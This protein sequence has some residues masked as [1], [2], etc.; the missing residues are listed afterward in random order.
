M[1]QIKLV[2]KTLLLMVGFGLLIVT[3][4]AR[5]SKQDENE[6]YAERVKTA[7]IKGWTAYMGY[8]KGQDAVNPIAKKGHNWYSHSL[9]MTP[10]DAFSTMHVMG[11]KK[12]MGEAKQLIFSQLNFDIDMEIQQ[13]EIAI[14]IMGGL[15]SAYQLDGDPRFLQLA[16]DLGKRMLPVFESKTGMPYRLVNLKTGAVSGEITNPCEIGS[17][18]LEYGM[19]SKLTGN[20][21]YYEKCKR[22]VVATFDRRSKIGLVGTEININT[23]EWVNKSAHLS[24]RIDAYYEY[25]LKGWLLFGDKDLKRMWDIHKKAIAKYLAD[26]VSSGFWYGYADMDTGVRTATRFGALDCF[27]GAVLCL[28]RNFKS[29][30]KLQQSIYKMWTLKGLEPETIDYS[31]MNIIDKYYMIR[32]EAIESTYYLWHYTKDPQ[33]F[34]QGKQMFESIEKY[35][36]VDNGYV[37]IR[38]VETMEKWD[39]LESFF[40]A[41]TMKY[42]YLFFAPKDA[43][44]LDKCVLNTEAH[45]FFKTWK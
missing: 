41:E 11:L 24:G 33:Y 6:K 39:T 9:L 44:D 18:L 19:L 27:Y 37:Q 21:I 36:Q 7:F 30:K 34:E 42:C 40:F 16:E 3:A 31:S 12:E 26:D 15:L 14:R 20:P 22:G 17:M 13:F 25:L 45:P 29:A 43:L 38:N 5:S 1:I 32:P 23:G 8:A 35:C 28:D 10:V 4:Q 2:M